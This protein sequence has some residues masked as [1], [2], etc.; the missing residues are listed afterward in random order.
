MRF[1]EYDFTSGDHQILSL[2][3]HLYPLCRRSTVR[4]LFAVPKGFVRIVP[5]G[6]F[7]WPALMI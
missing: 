3:S 5:E 2:A 7:A 6:P 1:R 4:R